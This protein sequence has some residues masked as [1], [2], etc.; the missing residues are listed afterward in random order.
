MPSNLPELQLLDKLRRQ[1]RRVPRPRELLR[2]LRVRD[3]GGKYVRLR[4]LDTGIALCGL[5]LLRRQGRLLRQHSFIH[6][7]HGLAIR[8]CKRSSKPKHPAQRHAVGIAIRKRQ[9]LPKHS[10]S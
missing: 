10:L 4:Q 1:L 2:L 7:E 8:H 5:W 6:I 3:C 9:P